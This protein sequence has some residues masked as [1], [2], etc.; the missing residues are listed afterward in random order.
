MKYVYV[1]V[2]RDLSPE[3][4]AVQAAHAALE[5]GAQF[6]YNIPNNVNLVLLGTK[7]EAELLMALSYVKSNKI[8]VVEYKEEESFTSFATEPLDGEK[9]LLL[10]QYKTLRFE[11]GIL[12]YLR[13]F[14][15]SIKREVG[16]E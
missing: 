15:Q 16:D 7:N 5:C 11:R 3:Q 6:S 10:K 12:Y 14:F 1:F 2:R 8:K 13:L 9:R 4:R